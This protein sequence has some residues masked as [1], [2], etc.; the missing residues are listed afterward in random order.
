MKKVKREWKKAE[1]G[2]GVRE[3]ESWKDFSSNKK[4]KLDN[5][6]VEGLLLLNLELKK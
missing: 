4:E 1:R 2:L 6:I 3:E 5:G